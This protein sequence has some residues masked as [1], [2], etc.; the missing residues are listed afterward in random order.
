MVYARPIERWCEVIYVDDL[1]VCASVAGHFY[2]RR[3]FERVLREKDVD[4]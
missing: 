4:E 1:G 2:E 3:S